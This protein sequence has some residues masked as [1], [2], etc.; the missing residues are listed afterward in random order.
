MKERFWL[1]VDE[2]VGL[3]SLPRDLVL[4]VTEMNASFTRSGPAAAVGVA[5]VGGGAF[6]LDG[7]RK[8]AAT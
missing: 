4:L 7:V 3:N 8:K 2:I 5:V 6:L 1:G